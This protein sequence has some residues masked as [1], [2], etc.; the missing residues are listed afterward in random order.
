MSPLLKTHE[1][2]PFHKHEIKSLRGET[3]L[4]IM[5]KFYIYLSATE[6]FANHGLYSTHAQHTPEDN[7][8]LLHVF[9]ASLL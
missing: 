2:S 9:L 1:K 5:P 6:N 4:Q 8:W 7:V 3:P